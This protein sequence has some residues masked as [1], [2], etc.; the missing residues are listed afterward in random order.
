M[1]LAAQVLIHWRAAGALAG[2]LALLLA[3]ESAARPTL[4]P[5]SP[6]TTM[7][8]SEASLIG[9]PV[10]SPDGGRLAYLHG[11]DPFGQNQLGRV[12][13]F[14]ERIDGTERIQ[15]TRDDSLAHPDAPIF[16][17][18]GDSVIFTAEIGLG[19]P[20]ELFRVAADGGPPRRITFQAGATGFDPIRKAVADRRGAVYFATGAN[21]LH[22][23]LN[24]SNG[25]RVVYRWSSSDGLARLTDPAV[26]PAREAEVFGV[27]ADGAQVFY[28]ARDPD[29]PGS[30]TMRPWR[31][32]RTG[33]QL[34]ALATDVGGTSVSGFVPPNAA[35]LLIESDA[36]YLGTNG[37]RDLQMYRLSTIGAVPEQL[38]FAS[39]SGIESTGAD[40]TG[41]VIV[42]QSRDPLNIGEPT[43]TDRVYRWVPGGQTRL[44]TG[45]H[46][47][48]A[49]GG[50]RI[51]Y[52]SRSDSLG[53]NGDLSD[54]IFTVAS[55]GLDRRQHTRYLPATGDWP[56][57][58]TDGQWVVFASGADL[59]GGNGD[60]S[61]EIWVCRPDGSD[62]RRLTD[63]T[64]PAGCREPALAA[65][66]EFIAFAANADLVPGDNADGNWEIY[67]INRDGTGIR[68]ITRTNQGDSG[69]PRVSSDGKKVAFATTANVIIGQMGSGRLAYWRE[70][71]DATTLLTPPSDRAIDMVQMSDDG[72]RIAV[73]STAEMGGR[74]TAHQR[75][76]FGLSSDGTLFR[77]VAFPGELQ[78]LGLAL[79]PDGGWIGG[80]TLSG[81]LV[82]IPWFGTV[83]DTLI[84]ETDFIPGRPALARDAAYVSFAIL[85]GLGDFRAGDY[86]RAGRDGSGLTPLLG[87]T[88]SIA[89]TPA[90]ISGNGGVLAF[91]V[92]GVDTLN[93]DGG[94]EVFAASLATTPV[95]FL[96]ICAIRSP[97]GAVTLEWR[98]EVD[99]QHSAFVA[100][101]SETGPDGPWRDLVGTPGNAGTRWTMIDPAAGAGELWYRL[102]AVDRNGDIE[103][104]NPVRATDAPR[105]SIQLSAAPSPARGPV[106]VQVD[107]AD[108]GRQ[109]LRIYNVAG[110]PVVTLHEGPAPA[111]LSTFVWNGRDSGNNPAP[112]GI[113]FLAIEGGPRTRIVRIE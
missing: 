11:F 109:V 70:Q 49:S 16:T 17:L 74:N 105:P 26:D 87:H 18:S 48:V 65:T 94:R 25:R 68:Q 83:F 14:I 51:A 27:S 82:T 8:A 106:T 39:S 84:N 101:R 104:S 69:L 76:G 32:R 73:T 64:P 10:L 80:A 43:G 46:V 66:G 13:L 37:S 90:A 100:E 9:R 112:P 5:L 92:T 93:P 79:S 29:L 62:R 3:G 98:A 67:R 7:P 21:L 54:E 30:R 1:R 22:E 34:T 20:R 72:T 75:L 15:A 99:D 38:T 103:W 6:A 61:V 59:D 91:A 60:G 63:T 111:G 45:R 58:S 110:Q 52:V 56:G 12:Q 19:G 31:L 53:L 78:A 77:T 41:A 2:A 85:S 95:R 47:S 86:Y 57:V 44:S 55:N 108:A 35:W 97:G 42:F 71:G 89:A 107:R 113:Y 24:L 36:D 102:R 40:S 50:G 81:Q 28:S 33:H 88:Q 96:A 23:N 4:V